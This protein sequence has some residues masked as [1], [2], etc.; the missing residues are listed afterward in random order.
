MH[1]TVIAGVHND[2][3]SIQT[4][5]QLIRHFSNNYKLVPVY[6]KV[7]YKGTEIMISVCNREKIIEDYEGGR[8]IVNL[9]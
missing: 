2:E 9:G 8:N 5:Y 7:I 6:G 1:G 3:L 4:M